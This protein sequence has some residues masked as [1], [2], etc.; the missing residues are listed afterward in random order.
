MGGLFSCL[1]VYFSV[2]SVIYQYGGSQSKESRKMKLIAKFY[3]MVSVFFVTTAIQ[4]IAFSRFFRLTGW[5]EVV[6]L[7]VSLA[8]TVYTL[9][10]TSSK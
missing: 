4:A 3:S 7:T 9:N 8:V 6:M 1:S 10:A 5:A 2:L